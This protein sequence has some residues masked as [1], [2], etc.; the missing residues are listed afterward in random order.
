MCPFYC[1]VTALHSLHPSQVYD[2]KAALKHRPPLRLTPR[3]SVLIQWAEQLY[4]IVGT[5]PDVQVDMLDWEP[6]IWEV[7]TLIQEHPAAVFVIL[8]SVSRGVVPV[9]R[10]RFVACK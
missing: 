1:L 8:G 3:P 4:E 6:V 9:S 10:G 7:A 2:V 5:D